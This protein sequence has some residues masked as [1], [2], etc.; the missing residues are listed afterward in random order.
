MKIIENLLE[1]IMFA[2]RWIMA[3][4]YLGL[5]VCLI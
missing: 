3:P 1:K 5:I 4:V 2:S